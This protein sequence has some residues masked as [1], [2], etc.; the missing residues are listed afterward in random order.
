VLAELFMETYYPKQVM[1][2]NTTWGVGYLPTKTVRR[3]GLVIPLWHGLLTVPRIDEISASTLAELNDLA[4][5]E[6]P[7]VPLLRMSAKTAQGF[8]ALTEMLNQEGAFGRK[9]LDLLI[10]S[11]ATTIRS[12]PSLPKAM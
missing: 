6:Y 4:T 1:R 12:F 10:W 9:I 7:A 3:P 5:K 11:A 2:Q 8:E